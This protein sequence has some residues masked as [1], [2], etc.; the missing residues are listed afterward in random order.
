VP[1]LAIVGYTNAGKSTLL[2]AI[3]GANAFVE[4]KLF[5]TLDPLSR[6]VELPDG[7][8]TVFTDT[9]GFIRNLPHTLIA[10]FRATLEEATHADV[11][12]LVLDANN[13]NWDEHRTVAKQVLRELD[14]SNS[15]IITVFNKIDLLPDAAMADRL[16]RKV[17]QSVCV[18]ALEKKNIE[19]L[20]TLVGRVLSSERR[21]LELAI[22][23]S[24]GELAA[25]VHEKGNVLDTKYENGLTVFTVELDEAVATQ[26]QEF[27]RES[28]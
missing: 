18:S 16:T 13:P 3:A 24:R 27:M 8:V 7:R 12:L 15:P 5:A 9:V 6:K 14:A 28:K 20:L 23:Q 1:N 25:M 11:L 26:F 21:I 17:P 19:D 4:D 2:N 22:P 10:A